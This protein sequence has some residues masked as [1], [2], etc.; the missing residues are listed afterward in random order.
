ML[1][2]GLLTIYLLARSKYI[3]QIMHRIFTRALAKNPN[4][5][6]FDYEQIL[7]LSKGYSIAK[8]NV[9]ENSWLNGKKLKELKINLEGVLV[10]SIYRKVDKK[11]MF[12][13]APSGDTEI[14]AGDLLI[15]YAREE[16]I[17]SLSIRCIGCDGDAD[18]ARCVQEEEMH[19]KIV[20]LK[21]GFE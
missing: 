5:K 16:E 12:I 18:H 10:L 7:G 1:I 9:K 4:L 17:Q 21:G 13:G 8:L 2:A 15:C 6:I 11:E 14:H 20:E 19:Q 3:Y